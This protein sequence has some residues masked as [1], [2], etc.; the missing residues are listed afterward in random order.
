M[1]IF[2]D[3][4]IGDVAEIEHTVTISDIEQFV[5]LTGDNNR[6]HTDA[7]Y[8]ASTSFKKPVAHGMLGASFI[9]TVI[10]TKLPGDGAL[11][12]S[13]SL[14]F[15]L[16]VRVGDTLAVSVEVLSKA[17][18][19]QTIELQTD[20]YNQHRQ[21][22]TT[23]IAKVRI[24]KSEPSIKTEILPER[25]VAL[26]IGGSGGIG[27]AICKTLAT[28]GFDVA[29]HCF[30][31]EAA[32]KRVVEDIQAGGDQ[33]LV[34]S[35]DI[36][37]ESAVE[38]MVAKVVRQFGTITTLV[39]CASAKIA[40]VNFS[41]LIWDD[42]EEHLVKTTKGLFHLTRAVAPIMVSAHYGKIILIGSQYVDDPSPNLLPYITAKSALVGF[43][44]S[45]A[46]ELAPKGVQVNIVSP[47]MTD[48]VQIADVPERVRLLTAAQ[49]PA[50]RLA[51]PEDV[52][53]AVAFL[54]SNRSDFLAGETIRVSGGQV[55]Q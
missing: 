7:E 15:I 39:N 26:V 38:E 9:S 17:E 28:D 31:N 6:I 8:A 29:V 50:R 40:A 45:L 35:A 41:N 16:P 27:S 25:R 4:K 18:R 3:I 34:V 37:S 53:G 10:G 23:G 11:W 13:Q 55:M 12:F 5:E 20:I 51:C 54:A 19:M 52:A 21:K 42:F 47:G 44:R 24:V 43:G 22:V 30:S 1:A 36:N 49:T 48:T 14:E 32:A 33:A 2:E 46:L